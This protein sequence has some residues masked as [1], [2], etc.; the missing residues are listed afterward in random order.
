M[1]RG[2]FRFACVGAVIAAS[3]ITM[4]SCG[5][6]EKS[7]TLE[8]EGLRVDLINDALDELHTTGADTFGYFEVNATS[9]VVNL[10]V[11]TDLDGAPNGDGKPDAVAQY[12]YLP[13]GE[14]QGPAEPLGANGPTFTMDE[15]DFVADS[16]LD[17]VLAELPTS[18]PSMFVITSAGSA[19]VESDRVEYRVTL[20]SEYGG[21]LSVLVSASGEVIGTDAD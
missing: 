21:E 3:S 9:R 1:H 19:D 4:S 12:V 20:L 5:G 6:S 2:S 10:F 14:L 16:V 7:T 8:V 17:T 15:V 18:T 11:A 13:T